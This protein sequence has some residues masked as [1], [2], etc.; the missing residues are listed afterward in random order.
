MTLVIA[1]LRW[2]YLAWSFC[3]W[4]VCL[5]LCVVA[6]LVGWFLF[7]RGKFEEKLAYAASKLGIT[8]LDY[9]STVSMYCILFRRWPNLL[10]QKIT[11][12]CPFRDSTKLQ[13]FTQNCFLHLS[14][15][16]K[17]IYLN[18]CFQ[19]EVKKMLLR[20]HFYI[21]ASFWGSQRVNSLNSL[22][23]IKSV[24]WFLVAYGNYQLLLLLIMSDCILQKVLINRH[25]H[26]TRTK[27]FSSSTWWIT[28]G[29]AQTVS[30]T[31]C[32]TSISLYNSNT[33]ISH[34]K[35]H[36]GLLKTKQNP[37]LHE[38]KLRPKLS[39]FQAWRKMS[40]WQLPWF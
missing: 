3:L 8:L 34:P 7:S 30:I 37:P 15:A 40:K 29:D 23:Q 22:H 35:T 38:W 33:V 13:N 39:H 24:N 25:H 28:Q 32:N 5:F 31:S 20:K 19:L 27:L 2:F 12:M 11:L 9:E 14:T 6:L 10:V 36:R 21:S 17:K 26:Q 18:L 4:V 16:C 1:E